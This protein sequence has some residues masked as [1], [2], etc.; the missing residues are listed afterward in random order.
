M[1]FVTL[2]TTEKFDEFYKGSS[3]TFV[4]MFPEEAQLYV[5]YF[6]ENGAAIN[7]EV[8][9]YIYTGKMIN[10]KY[11]LSGEGAFSEDIHFL[12]IP[13]QAFD[14]ATAITLRFGIGGRWFDDVV[15]NA[16]SVD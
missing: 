1:K 3:L 12:T 14:S 5:D 7:E 16:R 4:G 11:N 13:L 15:D 10:E 6:K 8:D 9:G 2:E